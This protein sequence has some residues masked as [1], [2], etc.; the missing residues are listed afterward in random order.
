MTHRSVLPWVRVPVAGAVAC[1]ASGSRPWP[2]PNAFE[3]SGPPSI[4][5]PK[6]PVCLTGPINQQPGPRGP[7][8]RVVR[9]PTYRTVRPAA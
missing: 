8:Q 4:L 3:L 5:H 6:P 1:E 2:L 9:Q 7:L